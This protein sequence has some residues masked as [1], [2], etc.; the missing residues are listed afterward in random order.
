MSITSSFSKV[1][2]LFKSVV[3]ANEHQNYLYH[4]S[5]N[6]RITSHYCEYT[7]GTCI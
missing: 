5:M 1:I 3:E 6:T 7:R 2:L 4:K